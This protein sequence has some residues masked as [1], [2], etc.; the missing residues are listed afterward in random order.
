M[1]SVRFY[2]FFY[3]YARFMFFVFCFAVTAINRW[4][5]AKKAREDKVQEKEEKTKVEAKPTLGDSMWG[6]AVEKE[7]EVRDV[8]SSV[9]PELAP[10]MVVR[11][12]CVFLFS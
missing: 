2:L 11:L 5:K 7:E 10:Y 8:C 1:V 3:K 6:D 4:E 12:S 9:T